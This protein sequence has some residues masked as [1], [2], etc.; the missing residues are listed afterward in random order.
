[1]ADWCV[2]STFLSFLLLI[3]V[4]STLVGALPKWE[5]STD[6]PDLKKCAVGDTTQAKLNSRFSL[7]KDNDIIVEWVNPNCAVG[8]IEVG[9]NAFLRFRNK[10]ELGLGEADCSV[11]GVEVKHELNN[12]WGVY[13]FLLYPGTYTICHRDLVGRGRWTEQTKFHILEPTARH[14]SYITDK[15]TKEPAVSCEFPPDDTIQFFDGFVNEPTK[16][17]SRC[18]GTCEECMA[19]GGNCKCQKTESVNHP[20]LKCFPCEGNLTEDGDPRCQCVVDPKRR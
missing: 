9:V 7:R 10:G 13:W 14:C 12:T 2:C 16:K 18:V 5:P 20:C 4:T 17:P 1:M 8:G 19:E 6:L 3:V 11:R 15:V